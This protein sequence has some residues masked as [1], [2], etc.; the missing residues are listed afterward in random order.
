MFAF[1]NE[2]KQKDREH[3]KINFVNAH[4]RLMLT[5]RVSLLCLLSYQFGTFCCNMSRRVI[6]VTAAGW[7]AGNTWLTSSGRSRIRPEHTPG[8]YGYLVYYGDEYYFYLWA[9]MHKPH[10]KVAGLVLSVLV[11]TSSR[12]IWLSG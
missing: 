7:R 8:C 1:S 4:L 5:M 2:N 12:A 9:G 11:I 3:F 6:Y 10:R